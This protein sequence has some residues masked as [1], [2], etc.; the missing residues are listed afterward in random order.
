[1]SVLYMRVGN[2]GYTCNYKREILSGKGRELLTL[3]ECLSSHCLRA[4]LT[5]ARWE[6]SCRAAVNRDLRSYSRDLTP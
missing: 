1:M 5:S 6:Q 4:T 3:T 2:L